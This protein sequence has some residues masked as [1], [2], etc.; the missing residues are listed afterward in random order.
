MRRSAYGA[1]AAAF[2]GL[3]DRHRWLLLLMAMALVAGAAVLAMPRG[4]SAHPPDELLEGNVRSCQALVDL[5]FLTDFLLEVNLEEQ[6]AVVPLNFDGL[7]GTLTVDVDG[8]K[9]FFDIDV[10]G[11]FVILAVLVKGGPNTALWLFTPD[12]TTSATGLHAPI[13]DNNGRPFGLSGIGAVCLG[14]APADLSLQKTVDDATPD[15][16]DEVTF[17]ITVTNAGPQTAESVFVEDVVPSG[18]TVSAGTIDFVASQG[19]A[20]LSGSTITWDVGDIAVGSETLEFD[21]TVDAPTG[22]TDEYLN[23]AQVDESD[24]FDPDSTPGNLPTHEDD[25]DT[26]VV[27]P[28]VAD[29]SLTKTV[30]DATPDGGD[31]VTFTITVTNAGPQTAESVFV[32][33]VVPSGYTVSA[34]TIDFVASQGSA[35]LSGS[36][37][38]WDVGDIAVGSETLEFDATVDAPTGT[39]DEY[40]NEAQ[41][42][43]SDTFDPDSTPGNL[44]THED[45]DDTAVVVPEEADLELTKTVDDTTPF[46]GDQ[47]IFTVSVFNDGPDAATNVTVEDVLPVGY[48]HVS[49]SADQ[50]SYNEGTDIWTIGTIADQGTVTLMITVTVNA[51]SDGIEQY[52]NCAE[53]ETSDQF[54]PD[55]TPGNGVTTEDDFDCAELDAVPGPPPPGA[56]DGFM[57]G[58]GNFHRGGNGRNSREFTWGFVL[59]CEDTTINGNNVEFVEHRAFADETDNFHLESITSIFCDIEDDLNPEPPD[60]GF[61]RLTLT[62]FGRFNGESDCAVEAIFTDSGEPGNTGSKKPAADFDTLKVTLSCPSGETVDFDIE[63]G[64]HQAHKG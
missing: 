54:D 11:D 2:D 30:D 28:N 55:S 23:E 52:T 25:D 6:D 13:N 62:G 31:E 63:G 51:P 37:I 26:A 61:D 4:A 19:S 33:D 38:T 41:V 18:Y 9:V 21:A 34:G 58:G 17:T 56:V 8:P 24:T 29:L 1:V 14:E 45:D 48:T 5:T 44:L 35:S 20:S 39:T 46:I 27:V 16:G 50:G 32:E 22:T 42:D 15:V 57:T 59:R 10:T 43:E 64:N 60:A 12:G 3:Q 49:D 7:T 47:V 53:V 36:T 40:L